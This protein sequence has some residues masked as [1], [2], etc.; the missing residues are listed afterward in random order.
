M[1]IK[2]FIFIPILIILCII[3]Y[4]VFAKPAIETR[5][6]VLSMAQKAEPFAVVAHKTGYDFS[7]NDSGL[8]AFSK[9]IELTCTAKDGKLIIS[10]KTNGKTYEGTYKVKSWSKF[11]NQS[12]TV[13]VDGVEGTANLTSR[14]G[15]QLFMSLG[16]YYLFLEAK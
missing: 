5:T 14:T 6:W 11:T 15:R 10:D 4:A 7:D 13:V 16:D 12:Y 3:L 8:F 2:K 9:E 1:K